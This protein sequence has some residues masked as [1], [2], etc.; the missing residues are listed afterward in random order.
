MIERELDENY[1]EHKTLSELAKDLDVSQSI[2]TDILSGSTPDDSKTK[3]KINKYFKHDCFDLNSNSRMDNVYSE[4][5]KIN[6]DR[7]TRL[8]TYCSYLYEEEKDR[9]DSLNNTSKIYMAAQ[10]FVLTVIGTKFIESK[11]VYAFTDS[12]KTITNTT[13]VIGHGLYVILVGSIVL[14]LVSFVL[15]VLVNKMW[16][17]ERLNDPEKVLYLIDQYSTENT[18]IAKIIA[19]YAVASNRN[20]RINDFKASLLRYSLSAFMISILLLAVGLAGAMVLL[21]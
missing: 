8:L 15:A 10:L 21:N 9:R 2:I 11:E 12:L 1:P 18:L 6:Y 5:Y 7:Y 19:D 4:Q 16:D 17:R 20:H 14:F 13:P 3:A